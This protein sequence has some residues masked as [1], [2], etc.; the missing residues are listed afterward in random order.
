MT[1]RTLLYPPVRSREREIMDD[2]DSDRELLEN[3]LRQFP[4]TNRLLSRMHHLLDRYFLRDMEARLKTH[5]VS[6]DKTFTILDVGAGA[7]DIPLWLAAQA[8]KRGIPVDI[9]CIDHDSR[10]VEFARE[11]V[12]HDPDVTV[13]PGSALDIAGR[14]DYIM[15]NHVLHHL[16]DGEIRRFFQGTY[17][18]CGRRILIN[19]LLRSYWSIIGFWLFATCF[20]RDSFART[21]GIISVRKGFRRVEIEEIIATCPW[22][23]PGTDYRIGHTLP[24]RLYVVATRD[25]R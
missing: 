21:D 20:L 9:T 24:G 5:R 4:R 13:Q 25:T 10:V 18:S 3:T 2:P 16:D 17:H 12:A 6:R 15:C 7:C 19:D 14:Y 22:S 1:W 11:R 23:T 8:R